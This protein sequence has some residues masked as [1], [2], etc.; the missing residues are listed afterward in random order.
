MILKPK[1][2]KIGARRQ[3]VMIEDRLLLRALKCFLR[4]LSARE[5]IWPFSLATFGRR[6]ERILEALGCP[7]AFTPGGLRAGGATHFWMIYRDQGSVRLR[8][9]WM[10]V[11]SLE[12]YLQECIF[13]ILFP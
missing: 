2:R 6:L 5:R 3:H 1:T 9:R 4:T 10:S 12:H 11:R 8:G 13:S 7:G